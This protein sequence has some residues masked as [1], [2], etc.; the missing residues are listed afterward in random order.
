MKANLPVLFMLLLLLLN[1]SSSG[2]TLP[3]DSITGK[4][5]YTEVVKVDSATKDKLYSRALEWFANTFKSAK[6]AIDLS[7]REAGFIKADNDVNIPSYK[8][9][10]SGRVLIA[11]VIKFSFQINCKDG[12]F[13]YI[14]T[15]LKHAK[16]RQDDAAA[17]SVGALEKPKENMCMWNNDWQSVKAHADEDIRKLINDL[18]QAMTKS[19]KG[20]P[21][22]NDW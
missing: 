16:I 1:N 13:K 10:G 8:T 19:S 7:D 6:S 9:R 18:V 11:G 17:C 3:I 22:K 21:T 2:Q 15:D 14:I 5:T 20:S 4:I 12:K